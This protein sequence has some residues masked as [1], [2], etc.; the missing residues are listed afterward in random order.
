M[1]SGNP[2]SPSGM[3]RTMK[4]VVS[5]RYGLEHLQLREIDIPALEDHQLLVRVRATSINP[6]EWYRAHGP[7]MVRVLGRD[8]LRAPRTTRLGSDLAGVVEAIGRDV[9]E[10]APGD[11]VFGTGLGAW[12]EYAVA[13]EP[14]LVRKPANV[15]WEEAAAVPIAATTALQALRDHGKVEAGQKVLING[16]S[17][18]VGT[19]T[20]QLAKWFGADV[21]AV[22]RTE[23]VEQARELGADRVVDYTQ[24]DFTRLDTRF[25]LMLDI[26]GSQPFRRYRRVLTPS[27]TIVQIGAKMKNAA[28]GPLPHIVKTRLAVIGRSQSLKFFIAQINKEDLAL[29]AELLE[30]GKM[31]SVV[32]R[33]FDLTQ[34][35][36]A[37]NYLGQGHSRGKN[38][39]VP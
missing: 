16:S 23:K 12:A 3:P 21:T 4:A 17:G 31:R 28:F 6:A 35:A 11:E 36:D 25:D 33:R 38:V 39:I 20:V 7:L 26:A 15:S 34:V 8:G 13:R 30:S 32:D 5:E 14:R 18:G 29:F 10:F 27:A 1:W 9:K 19:Y 2:S 24:E 37:V 22:C